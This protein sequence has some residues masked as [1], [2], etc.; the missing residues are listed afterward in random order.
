MI[1]ITQQHRGE[2]WIVSTS[3][4]FFVAGMEWVYDVTHLIVL[5]GQKSADKIMQ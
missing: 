4:V 2:F 1:V 5:T 3:E